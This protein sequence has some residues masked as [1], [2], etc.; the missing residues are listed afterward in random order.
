M[1][2]YKPYQIAVIIIGLFLCFFG[3]F[4]PLSAT[5]GPS[6]TQV[7]TIMTGGLL[8][9]LLVGVDWTSLA[10][11]LALALIPEYGMNKVSAGT[12]GNG[13]VFY[14]MLCFMLAKS[15]QATGVAHRLAVWFLTSSFSRKG[16]WCTI[17]MIFVS[18][19]VLSSGLS[20]SSTIM[21]FLPILYEIFESLG[22]EKG[23]G[24]A[25]PAVMIASLAIVCQIAQATT[26]ISH[27]MTLIGF[28]SYNSYTGNT[29]EFGQYVMAAMPVGI[30]TA[31]GWF[32]V[33]RFVWKPDV[34]R[35][36]RLDHDAIK[37]NQGPLTRQEKI[38]AAVYLA[39]VVLWLAPGISKYICPAVYPALNKI[40]QCYP[41]IAGIILLHFIKVE[42]RPVLSYK[43]AISAVP[44][45]TL[46]FMGALLHL[47]SALANTEIGV[48]AWLSDTIGVYCNGISP[49]VFVVIIAA[50]SVILTNFM[51][52]S[53]TCAICMAI[54]MPLSLGIYD[55]M[56]SPLLPAIMIT[57]GINFAFATAPATPPVAIA[58]D[59]GWISAGKLFQYGMAAGLV[60]ILV[61]LAVG[62]PIVNMVC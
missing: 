34:S 24:D 9:W 13:T 19:F 36:S 39:V 51:S 18:I 49:M 4:L 31:V 10:M 59:S 47:G 43:D 2:T 41:P 35:L 44:L 5:L 53:V 46:L 22:Y 48:A 54:A 3:R 14:L 56:I 28:S 61:M 26:P 45:G 38:A 21:I 29:M 16:A 7:L 52:N 15:L 8:M 11:I 32:L 40:Q 30:L 23:K 6:G 50:L 58:A 60:G 57:I 33:C 37:G 62:M 25:F 17:A 27:A 42:G 12:L 20:S 1:K 55:G